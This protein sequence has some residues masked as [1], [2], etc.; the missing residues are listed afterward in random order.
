M[1]PSRD[2]LELTEA[3]QAKS[4]S[5][6]L[7][8][9]ADKGRAK[10]QVIRAQDIAGMITETTCRLLGEAEE[11]FALDS[12]ALAVRCQ[13]ELGS[14]LMTRRA[15]AAL[16]SDLE[17][18]VVRLQAELAQQQTRVRE[19]QDAGSCGLE[20]DATVADEPPLADM[21]RR[22]LAE[23]AEIRSG[24]TQQVQQADVDSGTAVSSD[25]VAD[26][27]DKIASSIDGR[28][29]E[30][31]RTMN[32]KTGVAADDVQLAAL[33]NQDYETELESNIQDVQLKKAAGAGIA[34][35]LERLRKLRGTE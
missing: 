14:V 26:A 13:R 12:E 30:F 10:F 19:L 22:V 34:G 3:L 1:D 18:E 24:M 4:T 17:A 31:G 16:R 25:H 9:L 5:V 8:E 7:H 32:G 28:L 23:M 33:F 11:L 29:E 21:M 6:T 15:E 2:T 35:N 20:D 27:L